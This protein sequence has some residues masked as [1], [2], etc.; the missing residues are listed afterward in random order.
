MEGVGRQIVFFSVKLLV[1]FMKR[2]GNGYYKIFILEIFS[3][4]FFFLLNVISYKPMRNG[5][6]I[7]IKL[8]TVNKLYTI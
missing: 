5:K 7:L 1:G 6:T 4:P 3:R 8:Y 2:A